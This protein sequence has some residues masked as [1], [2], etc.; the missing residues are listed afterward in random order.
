[1]QARDLLSSGMP[2]GGIDVSIEEAGEEAV[3]AVLSPRRTRGCVKTETFARQRIVAMASH[4]DAARRCTTSELDPAPGESRSVESI[5]Q[6]AGTHPSRRVQHA[7][8]RARSSCRRGSG[9][10]ALISIGP[11]IGRCRT[12]LLAQDSVD[13]SSRPFQRSDR[14]VSDSIFAFE[15]ASDLWTDINVPHSGASASESSAASFVSLCPLKRAR[16]TK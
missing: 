10:C 11:G 3:R 1:M 2:V 15:G 8:R 7:R 12:G 13:P 16:T 4:E 9:V 14:T 5:H 6:T